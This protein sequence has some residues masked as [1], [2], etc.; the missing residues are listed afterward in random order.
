MV[1]RTEVIKRNLNP[2]WLPVTL[3]VTQVCNADHHRPIKLSV[4]DW[5]MNGSHTHIGELVTTVAELVE[6]GKSAS[7]HSPQTL[8][9]GHDAQFWSLTFLPGKPDGG[10]TT[11]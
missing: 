3:S 8:A 11:K 1:H 2:D 7:G 5:N 4:D 6:W 9:L 10:T